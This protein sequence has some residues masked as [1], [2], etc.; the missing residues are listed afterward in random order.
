MIKTSVSSQDLKGIKIDKQDTITITFEDGSRDKLYQN[1]EDG[2][3]EVFY[4]PTSELKLTLEEYEKFV[5]LVKRASKKSNAE[6]K[7]DKYIISAYSFSEGIVY[8]SNEENA[9][10][11]IFIEDIDKL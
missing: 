11:E 7:Q 10:G 8:F 5:K 1:T 9:I 3:I 4:T 2:G 6:Y